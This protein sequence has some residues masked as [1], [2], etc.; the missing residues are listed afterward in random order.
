MLKISQAEPVHGA[1]AL[2]VEGRLAGPWV[3]E[4]YKACKLIL[5]QDRCLELD[6]AGLSYVNANGVIVLTHFKSCGVQLQNCSPLVE[7]QLKGPTST[8]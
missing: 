5:T 4:L 8:Q 3:D 2:K 1:V 6:L 7:A